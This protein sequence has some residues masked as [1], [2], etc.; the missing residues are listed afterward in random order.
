MDIYFDVANKQFA[1]P[2]GGA[3]SER[4]IPLFPYSAGVPV[5]LHLVEDSETEPNTPASILGEGW[6]ANAG[7][8]VDSD[9]TNPP[10]VWVPSTDVTVDHEA[11]TLV[12]LANC[13]TTPFR[14]AITGKTDPVAAWFGIKLYAP[15]VEKPRY[16]YRVQV[17][18]DNI[19]YDE[20][21]A[22]PDEPLNNYFTK[23][24][25][26]ALLAGKADSEDLEALGTRVDALECDRVATPAGT[27]VAGKVYRVSGGAWVLASPDDP[28]CQT[29]EL[30]IA[31]GTDP[32][33]DNMDAEGLEANTGWSWTTPHKVLWLHDDGTMT[34]T[35]PNS[36]SH[37]GRVARPVGWVRDA[38]SIRFDGHLPG[39][40]FKGAVS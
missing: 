33:T 36:T 6:T 30:L 23:S 20:G 37:A 8:S 12:F 4:E 39:A 28:E 16:C 15:G 10:E 31:R 26:V 29:C 13:L 40:T 38:T 19:V 18:L 2:L 34:E 35:V 9:E 27:T 5:T 14:N 22:P 3:A 7:I 1:S 21:V 25:T 17:Y 32:E 24:E 11:Q